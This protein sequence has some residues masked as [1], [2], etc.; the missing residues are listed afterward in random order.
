MRI[1]SFQIKSDQKKHF[2]TCILSHALSKHKKIT[3]MG[4]KLNFII[5]GKRG[6]N[7]KGRTRN[8]DH[9]KRRRNGEGRERSKASGGKGSEK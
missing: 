8:H 9:E 7:R 6:I 2:I 3:K 4:K 5:L 1:K